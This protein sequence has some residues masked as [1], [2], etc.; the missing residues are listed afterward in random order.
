MFNYV[1]P[2]RNDD[3]DDD[4]YASAKDSYESN[5]E[6]SAGEGSNEEYWTADDEDIVQLDGFTHYVSRDGTIWILP[7]I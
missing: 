2:Q 3:T 5:E 6:D 4:D 7:I 1:D